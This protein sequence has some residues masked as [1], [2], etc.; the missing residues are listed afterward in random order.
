M[1]ELPNNR[2]Q[3]AAKVL[4]LSIGFIYFVF[5]VLKFFHGFSPAEAI[6]IKTIHQLTFGYISGN[7]ALYMLA[8]WECVVGIALFVRRFMKAALVLLFVHMFFTF[9]PFVFF[10]AETFGANY[11]GFTLLGQY[12]LKN[13]IIVSA[14]VVLWQQTVSLATYEA[15][16]KLNLINNTGKKQ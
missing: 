1:K 12:I 8:C 9:T 16:G 6:A 10:P 3:N 13:I 2:Q 14:G 5:G 15:A 7:T 4:S 11:Q